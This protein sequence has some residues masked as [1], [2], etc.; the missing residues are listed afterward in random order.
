[1]QYNT[2]ATKAHLQEEYLFR[3]GT[4]CIDQHWIGNQ[5]AIDLRKTSECLESF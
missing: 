4:Y 5:G 3:M 1:M 2:D